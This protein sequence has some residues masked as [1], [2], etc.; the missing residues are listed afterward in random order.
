MKVRVAVALLAAA[1][2]GLSMAFISVGM[3]LSMITVLVVLLMGQRSSQKAGSWQALW[4]TRLILVILAVFASSLLWTT[5]PLD[6][7]SEAIGKSGKFLVIPALMLLLGSRREA[8]LALSV[9]LGFQVFSL[10]SSWLLY[11]HVP[12]IWATGK[13]AREFF[14]V[15]ATYLDQSIMSAVVAALF[16][17]LRGLAPN[18]G[19]RYASIG[20]SWLALGSVFVVFVGRTGQLVGLVMLSLAVYWALPRRFRLAAIAVPPLIALLAFG[21]GAVPSRF[22]TAGTEVSSYMEKPAATTS[23][24]IRLHFWKTSLEAIARNPVTGSG[25]G[26]WTTQFNAIELQKNPDGKPLKV[27]SN[28]HQEFLLWGVQF[29]VGGILLLLAFLAAMRQ[30]FRKMEEPVARA[31]QS[32]VAALAVS[33]LF[34]SSLYDAHIGSFFC[35]TLGVLMAYGLN[36]SNAS[37]PCVPI[38]Q[39]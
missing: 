25:L 23:T 22:L 9:L 14:A 33:C 31:G 17:H 36:G 35:L 28:P 26:S 2:A 18:R 37:N 38:G 10:L 1:S 15:F 16:W 20:I 19:L 5:G 34:N 6:Q 39:A 29:G 3:F 21:L 8:S 7:V 30:D 12:V 27:A 11:F 32:V 13:H 24:G 4:T